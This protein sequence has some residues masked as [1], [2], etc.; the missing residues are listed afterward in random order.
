MR[1]AQELIIHVGD[2]A[3]LAVEKGQFRVLVRVY[4]AREV[5]GRTD[6][7]VGPESCGRGTAWI[8][9]DRL[10]PYLTA[11]ANR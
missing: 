1:S 8:S 4:D 2:T 9:A 3:E 5:W 7:L 6:Y 11:P 10:E